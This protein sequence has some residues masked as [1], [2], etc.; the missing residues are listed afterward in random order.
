MWGFI[1]PENLPE[2]LRS[3]VE[4]QTRA[5]DRQHMK[6]DHE[7][8]RLLNYLEELKE[9]ESDAL[10]HL[11]MSLQVLGERAPTMVAHYLGILRGLAN[12][13]W[14]RCL[15][16][17]VDHAADLLAAKGGEDGL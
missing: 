10:T 6:A 9:E 3:L 7:Y 17:G 5:H 13:K 11:L 15:G 1:N 16:C 14:D 4:E 8:H 2:N 12:R